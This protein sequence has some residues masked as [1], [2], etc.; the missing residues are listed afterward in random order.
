MKN[1]EKNLE[2]IMSCQIQNALDEKHFG[3]QVFHLIPSLEQC[4]AVAWRVEVRHVLLFSVVP[5]PI[6]GVGKKATLMTLL[7][8]FPFGRR[9]IALLKTK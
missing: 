9:M 2:G 7:S 3:Y 5:L 8:V 1:V 6:V 4:H